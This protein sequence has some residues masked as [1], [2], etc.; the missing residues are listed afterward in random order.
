MEALALAWPSGPNLTAT[1]KARLIFT[2]PGSLASKHSLA[3]AT[4]DIY[5]EHFTRSLL[6]LSLPLGESHQS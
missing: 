2:P 4:S 6:V 1:W 3:I 5:S